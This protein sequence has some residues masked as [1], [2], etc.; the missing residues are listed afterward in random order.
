MPAGNIAFAFAG[1][2]EADSTFHWLDLA[3]ED[4]SEILT[5]TKVEPGYDPVR[6]DP[7]FADVLRR[8]GLEH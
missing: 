5:V 7:R 1:L 3:I 8:V 4:R 2:G 6:N